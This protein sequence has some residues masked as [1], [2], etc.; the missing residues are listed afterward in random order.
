MCLILLLTICIV[1]RVC[2]NSHELIRKYGLMCCRQCFHSNA[3]EIG[4]IKVL[5]YV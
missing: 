5:F 1:I 2:G 3:K 4:F